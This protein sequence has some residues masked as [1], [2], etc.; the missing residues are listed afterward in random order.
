MNLASDFSLSP[1]FVYDCLPGEM[2][3]IPYETY[4]LVVSERSLLLKPLKF[5]DNRGNRRV[6]CCNEATLPQSP[7]RE[8]G[9]EIELMIIN[10]Q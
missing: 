3:V 4:V 7:A 1:R 5:P 9:L 8:E 6:F 2:V 10:G